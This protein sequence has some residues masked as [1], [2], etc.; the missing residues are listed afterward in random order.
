MSSGDQIDEDQGKPC[1]LLETVLML[2][3]CVIGLIGLIGVLWFSR[4]LAHFLKI[5]GWSWL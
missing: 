2:T 1:S 4:C 3:G 5:G